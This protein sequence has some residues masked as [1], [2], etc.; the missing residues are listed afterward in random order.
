M[1]FVRSLITVVLLV[2]FIALWFWAWRKERH[3]DFAMAARLPLEDE[4]PQENTQA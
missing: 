1:T 4:M 3:D 2:A